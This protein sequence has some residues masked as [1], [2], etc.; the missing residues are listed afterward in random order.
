MAIENL[1]STGL[2][3]VNLSASLASLVTVSAITNVGLISNKI[4]IKIL[5]INPPYFEQK[6]TSAVASAQSTKV[7]KTAVSVPK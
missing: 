5:S 6:H 7:P 4:V 3:T 1:A 2:T